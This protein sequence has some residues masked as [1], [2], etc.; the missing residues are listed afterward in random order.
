MPMRKRKLFAGIDPG[1][2]NGHLTVID[3]DEKLVHHEK[4][5]NCV[6]TR[7]FAK[8]KKGNVK[9]STRPDEKE[10]RL[11]FLRVK[12]LGE[13]IAV[14]E[15]VDFLPPINGPA[16]NFILGG[17]YYLC[18]AMCEWAEF[19]YVATEAQIWQSE[20]WQVERGKKK[21]KGHTK[22]LSRRAA[23]KENPELAMLLQQ[24]NS[25]GFSDSLLL[26]KWRRRHY[27]GELR[28]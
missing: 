20:F 17:S 16:A 12:E 26:A 2:T 3:E 13:I 21:E 8:T 5:P 4:L 18:L 23:R 28:S 10:T 27:F 24:D 7:K 22:D 6:I 14:V 25:D 15:D 11:V 19:D 9:K 1:A